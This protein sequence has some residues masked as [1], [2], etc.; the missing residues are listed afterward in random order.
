MGPTAEV[1]FLTSNVILAPKCLSEQIPSID[2]IF[3]VMSEFSDVQ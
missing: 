3:I 2:L 1:A